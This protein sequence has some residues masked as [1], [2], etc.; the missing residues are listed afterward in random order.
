MLVREWLAHIANINAQGHYLICVSIGG[1][2][3]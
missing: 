3:P 2:R 1:V